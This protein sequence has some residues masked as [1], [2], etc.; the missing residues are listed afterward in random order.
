MHAMDPNPLKSK[1]AIVIG[2]SRGSY[3]KIIV[4]CFTTY[5]RTYAFTYVIT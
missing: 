5:V 2:G 1:F 4:L 3:C